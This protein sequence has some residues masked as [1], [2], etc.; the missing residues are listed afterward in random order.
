MRLWL[1]IPCLPTRSRLI[2]RFVQCPEECPMCLSFVEEE[3]HLF[4]HCDSI[5]E[6]WHAMGLTNIMQ[7]RLHIF[8][9]VRDLILDICKHETNVVAGKVAVLLWVAWQNRNNKVWNDTCI[10]AQQLGYQAARYW[11]DWAVVNSLLQDQ[12]QP[13]PNATAATNTVLW[14]QPP[15]GYLKCNVDASFYNLAGSTG[16]GWVLRDS[17]GCFKLAGS[18]IVPTTLSVLEGETMALVEAME[19]VIQRGLPYVIFESDSKLVVEAIS[20]RQSGVSEF[21]LLISHIQSLL[22][23]HNYFEVKYVRRQANKIAHY[24]A[25][26]AVSMSRRCVFDSVPRCIETYLNNEMC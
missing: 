1:T 2:N 5:R 10:Q 24:L 7:P 9:N 19:E 8:T 12:L 11:H 17:H 16:W 20:S 18:N 13:A 22:R 6:A 15:Q 14:Q 26:A 21:S 4:F 3:L 23:L 25:R